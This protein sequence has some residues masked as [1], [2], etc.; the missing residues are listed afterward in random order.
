MYEMGETQKSDL[1]KWDVIRLRTHD[2]IFAYNCGG[3]FSALKSSL[4]LVFVMF[5]SA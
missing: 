1:K 2:D 5:F 3:F 4:F